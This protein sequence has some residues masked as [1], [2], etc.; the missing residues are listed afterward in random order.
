MI[1]DLGRVYAPGITVSHK[2]DFSITVILNLETAD[3]T[4]YSATGIIPAGTLLKTASA[5]VGDTIVGNP[6]E[7]VSIADAT[8]AQG[9]LASDIQLID[10]TQTE[11]AV[12]VI[13]SGVVYTDAIE[14]ANGEAV[15]DTDVENLAKQGILFYNIKTLK[16]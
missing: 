12:G 10:S 6:T 9:I 13:I 1:R 11:Y 14:S 8:E 5:T 3:I 4:K 7:G 16:N 15:S 2:T